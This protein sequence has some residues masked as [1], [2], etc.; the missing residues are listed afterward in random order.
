[1][2]TKL[3]TIKDSIITEDWAIEQLI[4]KTVTVMDI[5]NIDSVSFCYCKFGINGV[6]QTRM[7]PTKHLLIHDDDKPVDIPVKEVTE[8][9]IIDVVKR[10]GHE[11]K[12]PPKEYAK[13][14]KPGIKSKPKS[15]KSKQSSQRSRSN[16][17]NKSKHKTRP[18]STNARK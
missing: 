8:A 18:H 15:T 16:N 1:M 10:F 9:P 11:I 12:E 13:Y 7:I 5:V 3:A 2:E 4:G 6:V 17:S 14:E